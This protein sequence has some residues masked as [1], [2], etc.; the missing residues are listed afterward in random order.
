MAVACLMDARF[1]FAGKVLRQSLDCGVFECS[2]Y[3]VSIN[4]CDVWG[5]RDWFRYPFRHKNHI[6]LPLS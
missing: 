4:D 5:Q 1:S 6:F 2:E 3:T